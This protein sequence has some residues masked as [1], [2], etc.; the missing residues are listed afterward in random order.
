MRRQRSDSV[1]AEK[2]SRPGSGSDA[3]SRPLRRQGS[4]RRRSM[5][6]RLRCVALSP[7]SAGPSCT[8]ES[9]ASLC[10]RLLEHH[11][12]AGGHGLLPDAGPDDI[13]LVAQQKLRWAHGQALSTMT[14]AEDACVPCPHPRIH[15]VRRWETLTS[16]CDA[17][18]TSHSTED[19]SRCVVSPFGFAPAVVRADCGQEFMV[20]ARISAS[21][22]RARWMRVFTV[23]TLTP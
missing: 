17:P 18:G 13:R 6:H 1:G 21:F 7:L 3:G 15:A 5:G 19:R 11:T 8:R 20:G 22:F 12:A 2:P 4:A 9:A 23:A 10:S 16:R 14:A